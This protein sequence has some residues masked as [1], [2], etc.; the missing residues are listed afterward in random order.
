MKDGPV[1]GQ[2]DCATEVRSKRGVVVANT[3]EAADAGARILQAGGNAIDA[4]VATALALGVTEAEAS[5]LGG[6]AWI[7]IHLA[8]G[9]DFAI[10]GSGTLP[11]AM[12]PA[13]IQRLKDDGLP[14][15]YQMV[16][17]PGG[18]AALDL[19]LRSFGTRTLAEVMV[20]AIELARDG[21]RLPPHQEAILATYGWRLRP[22]PTLADVFL[23]P[24]MDP[25]PS[26]HPLCMDSLAGTMARL[27]ERGVRDFYVGGMAEAIEADMIANGGYV[28]RS[29]LAAVR[30]AVLQPVRGHYR[31]LDVVSFPPPGGG[32][33]VVEAL[34]ILDC[35]RP[36]SMAENTIASDVLVAQAAHVA[37]V[38]M[39]GAWPKRPLGLLQNLSPNHASK[40]AALIASGRALRDAEILGTSV[41]M[42]ALGGTTHVSVL[43]AMGNAVALT[44][45]Y[46]VEFG[47]AV[48]SPGLG[49]IYN[50]SLSLI[51]F[52]RSDP[53]ALTPGASASPLH[54]ASPTILLRSGRP[55]L[56]LGGPGSGRI[57]STV[58]ST[59]VKLVDRTR[60]PGDAIAGPRVLWDGGR[61]PELYIEV[62]P[63]YQ[64]SD[65]EELQSRGFPSIYALRF[66]AR[67]IDLIAFGG[68]NLISANP[69]TGEA[70]GVGD[71]RRA[72]AVATGDPPWP[73]ARNVRL[74]R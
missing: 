9:R 65:V 43:D 59:V 12:V 5:G 63:P 73:A 31:G 48:A 34:Q 27:A 64:E 42:P 74:P 67:V 22:A 58:V 60:R 66:P 24:G 28:R 39:F 17:T 45:T 51:D 6:H 13:E 15:G 26:S 50:G 47:A 2:L 49:F 70:V 72:G 30:P 20:P 69:E 36:E 19:A 1:V 23:G 68:V 41:R 32:L 71:P 46:N 29:D 25:W 21:V 7:L 14:F 35:F 52:D 4:A 61:T 38:D 56:V 3:Q 40:R 16:A 57:T 37:L 62:A 18:L 10:D 8:N 44:Q 11:A 53:A 54:T 33:A 55:V